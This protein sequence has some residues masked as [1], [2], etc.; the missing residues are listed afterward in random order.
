MLNIHRLGTEEEEGNYEPSM[1]QSKRLQS[2]EFESLRIRPSNAVTYLYRRVFLGSCESR[3]QSSLGLF[4]TRL[5]T[6]GSGINVSFLLVCPEPETLFS[7]R[8]RLITLNRAETI[9]MVVI[10]PHKYYLQLILKDSSTEAAHS[11]YKRTLDLLRKLVSGIY[12]RLTNR[13]FCRSAF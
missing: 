1:L 6:R 9:I 11:I 7:L 13:S 10:K 12:A 2:I 3:S 8:E 4:T 5:S